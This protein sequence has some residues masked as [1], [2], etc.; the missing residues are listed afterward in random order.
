M[1]G[2]VSRRRRYGTG[3]IFEERGQW[4]PYPGAKQVKRKLGP[5][6]KPGSRH[7]ITEKQAE[8]RLREL[9]QQVRHA[10]PDERLTVTDAGQRYLHHLTALGRKRS[11]LMDYES[12]LRVHLAPYFGPVAIDRIGPE[13]VEGFMAAK[14]SEGKAPKSVLNYVGLLHSIFEHAQRRGWTTTNP[15]KLVDKPRVPDH[16]EIRF[17]D[18]PS[19]KRCY[20]PSPTTGSAAPR[21]C[22]T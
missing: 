17:L 3:S 15:C 6:R 22:C 11:T 7:G 21:R 4:R 19:S 16:Q 8:A 10:A 5:K 20:V 2:E 1:Q 18:R 13:H 14:A 12:T 9:M